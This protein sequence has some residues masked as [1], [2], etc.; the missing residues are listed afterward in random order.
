[1]AD[2]TFEFE[3]VTLNEISPSMTAMTSRLG[4]AIE[5]SLNPSVNLKGLETIKVYVAA[6]D[7]MLP[8][9]DIL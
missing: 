8:T 5:I 9:N 3:G 1:M 2:L 4:T 6:R 7:S